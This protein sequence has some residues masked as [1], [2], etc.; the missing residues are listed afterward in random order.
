MIVLSKFVPR[1]P[2]RMVAHR[3]RRLSMNAD[4]RNR[5]LDNAFAEMANQKVA[6][7]DQYDWLVANAP[8]TLPAEVTGRSPVTYAVYNSALATTAAPVVQPTGT[9][10]RTMLQ[11]RTA[12]GVHARLSAWGCSFDGSAAAT[13]GKVE[14]FENTAAATMSTAYAAADIQ[15]Y[16]QYNATANTAGSGGTP[17]NLSTT[18][19]GFATAS[20]TEGTVA[21]YRMADLALIAPTNQYVY[22]WPLGMEFELTPQNYLRC[23][24]TFGTTVNMYIWILIQL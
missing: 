19:S 7:K 14:L 18:T 24:V 11:L 13:P 22:Q 23:R 1:I 6:V 21:G 3:D 15:P 4:V 17:F 12:T 20:V 9:A 8:A 10:I 16:G 5:L 2:E